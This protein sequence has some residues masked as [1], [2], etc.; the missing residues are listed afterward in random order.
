VIAK[1]MNRTDN[2][3]KNRRYAT[4]RAGFMTCEVV[5]AAAIAAAQGWGWGG[6]RGSAPP[7]TERTPVKR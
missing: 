7:A 4:Q 6:G 5:A 1:K 2:K 3:A